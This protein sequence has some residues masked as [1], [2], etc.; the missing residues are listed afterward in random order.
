VACMGPQLHL[1]I[2][3]GAGVIHASAQQ[4]FAQAQ[5]ARFGI[6]QKQ[7]QFGCVR[8][9]PDAKDAAQPAPIAVLGNPAFVNFWIVMRE[10]VGRDVIDQGAEGVI[11]AFVGRVKRGVAFDQPVLV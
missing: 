4:L 3:T 11:K 10:E 8:I 9:Q 6:N 7:P 5:A 2:A 1:G